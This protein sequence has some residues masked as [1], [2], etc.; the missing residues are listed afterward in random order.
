MPEL[1]PERPTT[2][3]DKMNRAAAEEMADQLIDRHNF[4]ASRERIANDL[5]KSINYWLDGY[6]LAKDLE[7]YCHWNIDEEVVMTLSEMYGL[8]LSEKERCEKEW[9]AQ[10]NPQP[11]F[12]VGDEVSFE[13]AR[14]GIQTGPIHSIYEEFARYVIDVKR[15]GTGGV[16]I[17]YENVRAA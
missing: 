14:E 10:T 16:L 5:L 4:H 9:V 8:R 7:N 2:Y 15:T 6:H 1:P 17:P 11:A 13:S 3:T 12:S